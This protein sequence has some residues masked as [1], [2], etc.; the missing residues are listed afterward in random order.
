[1]TLLA[2]LAAS[3]AAALAVGDRP[4][5]RL[6]APRASWPAVAAAGA[7]IAYVVIRVPGAT[8]LVVLAVG[9]G[10]AALLLVRRRSR[11]RAAVAASGRVLETCELL[12]AELASGQPPGRALEHAAAAWPALR[13]VAEAYDL[14]GDVP[15]ALRA[16]GSTP[17]AADLR[18][19]AASWAVA[20][21]TGE[22]LA[23]AVRRCADSIRSAHASRRLVEGE[24]A[25][26]RATVR[27]VAGLPVLALLMGSGAGGD[28]VGF[29]LGHP[30][31]LACLG[32]R[33]GVR[34]RR[35][36]VDRGDRRRRG[37]RVMAVLA[38]LLTGVVVL[39][40]VPPTARPG[41]AAGRSPRQR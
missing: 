23:D 36:V 32:V 25:S 7:A 13:P 12:S 4:G 17:G 1:M 21:R 14:G 2:V 38:G 39:L 5:L 31:G 34:V 30:I 22:G 16:A 6:A 37:R 26:A 8:V 29:L 27:M 33:P 41:A 20:H 24:L 11:D 19:L 15:A 10:L 3:V 28:P 18:L 40:L 9:A 35:P